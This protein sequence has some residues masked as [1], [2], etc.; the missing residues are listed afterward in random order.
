MSAL[1]ALP[2]LESEIAE[3]WFRG[4]GGPLRL[5]DGRVARVVFPGVPGPGPGPDARDAIIE[6]ENDLLRG[7]IE[8]HLRASGWYAHGHH[9]DSAYSGVVLHVVGSND[10]ASAAIPVAGR[11]PIPMLVLQSLPIDGEP[12][13]MFVPPC[14][15][16]RSRETNIQAALDR[17][18]ERRLRIK[19]ARLAP[20]LPMYGPGGVLYGAILEILGGPA[21]RGAF[22]SLARDLPLP[23]LLERAERPTA[24]ERRRALVAELRYAGASLVLRSAGQRPLAS[25]GKRLEL[26]A[27]VVAHL[28]P[29]CEAGWPEKL[30][31][32]AS[33]LKL[34]QSAGLGRSTAIE[35]AVNAILPVAL[36][37]GQWH[38]EDIR[39]AWRNLPSPG[40]YGKLKRLTGWL[41]RQRPETEPKP[42]ATAARLQGGLLL[43][44]EYCAKGKVRPL[45]ALLRN[46]FSRSASSYGIPG[47]GNERG[48]P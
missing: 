44:T 5:E 38:E 15:F 20:L 21:N 28:W 37:S 24:G 8:F 14:V 43:H 1:V 13:E 23:A 47:A 27:G 26:A 2:G 34:L 18:G 36:A 48:R 22:A 33:L 11:L 40:T 6:I 46:P 32:G 31:Q 19:A 42:F 45:P 16:A 7:D 9:R 25:P 3:R 10:T 12:L 17:L 35:T 39:T 41:E 29:G 4:A 30:A